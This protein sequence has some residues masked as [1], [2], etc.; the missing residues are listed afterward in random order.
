MKY[1]TYRQY[2]LDFI[3]KYQRK[4]KPSQ[5]DQKRIKHNQTALKSYHKRA[6]EKQ[7]EAKE[8][9]VLEDFASYI[10][11]AKEHQEQVKSKQKAKEIKYL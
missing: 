4:P 3:K 10:V 5:A 2:M 11:K 6:K 9:Q 1:G 8:K 7:A